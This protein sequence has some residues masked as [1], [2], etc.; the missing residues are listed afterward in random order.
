[1]SEKICG[2]YKITNL[3]NGKVYIGQSQDI[4]SRWKEHKYARNKR[5]CFA[6]YGAFKKYGLDNFS[7]EIVECCPFEQLNEKEIYYISQYHSYVGDT[8]S[9]GYNMTKGG[10]ICFTHVG[11]D[12]QGKCV[13][14]YDLDGNFMSEYRN[15]VKAAKA[16]GLKSSASICRAIKEH[17][18]AGGFQWRDYKAEKIEPFVNRRRNLLKVYQYTLDGNFIQE[19]NSI[20][21]AADTVNCTRGLIELCGAEKCQTGAGYRWSYKFYEKLP[22]L[23]PWEQPTKWKPVYQY[24][25]QGNFIAEYPCAKVA[26]E[27]TGVTI[28]A[29]R[30][31]VKKDCKTAYG[32]VFKYSKEGG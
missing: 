4:Y 26:S 13:Y 17:T 2:I 3:V 10:A 1:M 16:V 14:Q 18:H 29:I 20:Q 22:K 8:K 32:F 15:Y 5:D 30:H 24:D 11:N 27:K 12:D 23:E 31:C 28:S 19:F 7:F 25:T 21:E 9:N 6:L